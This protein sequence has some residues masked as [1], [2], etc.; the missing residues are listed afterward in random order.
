M[1]F[2]RIF[3]LSSYCLIASGFVAIGATKAV[4]WL[5]MCL[6]MAVFI[7]SW[8]VDTGSLRRQ[9]PN[10]ALNCLALTYLPFFAVDYLLLSRS[11]M[12]AVF[13]LLLFTAAIKLL[14]LSNDR[15][16]ILLYLISLAELLAASTLT[17]NIV[18][19]VCFL[20]FLFFAISTLVLFE[21]RRTNARI[22]REVR[23]QP[24]FVPKQLQGTG[25]ELFSPFPGGL[26]LMMVA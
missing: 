13:H 9:I 4:D 11:I 1:T 10:W 2:A 26:L 7:I 25:M 20:V 24:L 16:Y 8:F 21:M 17:V 18:F 12:L 22:Q 14:T 6:F 23:V 15:D 3:K 5:S 19:S